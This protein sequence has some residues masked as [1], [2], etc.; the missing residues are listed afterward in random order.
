MKLDLYLIPL[1]KSNSKWIQDLNV[2][3]ETM[4]LLEENTGI[5]FLNMGLGSDFLDMTPKG[6]ATKSKISKWD[7]I[8]LKSFCTTKETKY[9]MKKIPEWEK[10]FENHI[11]DKELIFNIYIIN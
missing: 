9:K 5:N 11:T 7:Y 8:K 2:R 4:K 1:T 3:P 10:I 6:Q